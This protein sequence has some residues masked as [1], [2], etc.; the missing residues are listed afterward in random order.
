MPT[1]QY[2]KNPNEDTAY[3]DDHKVNLIAVPAGTLELP[4]SPTSDS[5]YIVDANGKKHRV[6][7]ATFLSGK[8]DY[9][10]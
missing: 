7:L 4:I 8:I 2:K 1:T 10:S 9:K 6:L 5:G 3:F